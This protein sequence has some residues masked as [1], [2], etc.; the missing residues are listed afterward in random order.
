MFL[1]LL[2]VQIFNILKDHTGQEYDRTQIRSCLEKDASLMRFS[3]T[4]DVAGVLA[5]AKEHG[6]A[7]TP[8]FGGSGG[9]SAGKSA[10]G[11]S[12][13]MRTTAYSH[14]GVYRP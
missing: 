5:Y 8:S 7:T 3:A 12:A 13:T 14:T 1:I 2:L 10:A 4:F 11:A 6:I 9:G